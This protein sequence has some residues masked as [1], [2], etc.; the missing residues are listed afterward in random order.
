M[1]TLTQAAK[2]TKPKW[3]EDKLTELRELLK[4]FDPKQDG[5]YDCGELGTLLRVLGHNPSSQQVDAFNKLVDPEHKGYFQFGD[6][7]RSLD[8][9][10]FKDPTQAEVE[11]AL[12][13][14]DQERTGNVSVTTLKEVLMEYDEKLTQEE[15]DRIAK[16]LDPQATGKVSTKAFV[17]LIK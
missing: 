14:L 8:T 12:A 16:E 1:S 9:F 11:E 2:P 13:L 5:H 4:N 17:S 7:I 15:F 3:T 6:L 10:G